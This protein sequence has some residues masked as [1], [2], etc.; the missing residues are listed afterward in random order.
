MVYVQDNGC[1]FF[2]N[3]FGVVFTRIRVKVSTDL[4]VSG[5]NGF[6]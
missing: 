5:F 3:G 4:D 1:W 6:G 2:F